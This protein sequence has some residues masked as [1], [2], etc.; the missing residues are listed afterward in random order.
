MYVCEK[1]EKGKGGQTMRGQ[2][3]AERLTVV[4][5]QLILQEDV[6]FYH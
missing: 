2:S 5:S 3:L 6:A 4:G 1:K